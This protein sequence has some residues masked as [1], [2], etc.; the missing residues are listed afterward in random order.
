MDEKCNVEILGCILVGCWGM[1]VEFGGVVVFFVLD[2]FDYV[3]GIMLFVDGGWLFCWVLFLYLVCKKNV[4]YMWGVF[5]W[6]NVMN[7]VCGFYY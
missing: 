1:L 6:R 2:V 5:G 3:Y 7:R 4:L